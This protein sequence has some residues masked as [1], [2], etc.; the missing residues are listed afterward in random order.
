LALDVSKNM[1]ART[2][3]DTKEGQIIN[4]CADLGAARPAC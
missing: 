4:E 2:R 1:L 3:A